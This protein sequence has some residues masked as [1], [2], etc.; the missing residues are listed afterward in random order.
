MS[1]HAPQPRLHRALVI[2]AALVS[3]AFMLRYTAG[4]GASEPADTG[5]NPHPVR[6]MRPQDKPLT[7]VALLGRQIFF[8]PSLSASGKQSCSSC[9]SPEHGYGPPGS[10][11]VQAGGLA[12]TTQGARAVPS[13]RYLYRTPNFS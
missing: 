6:L 10:A 13:L 8:D 5:I 3:V 4:A 12:G 1:G 9:H 11:S 2:S 7:A